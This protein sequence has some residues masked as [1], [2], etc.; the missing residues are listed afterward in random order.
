LFFPHNGLGVDP[1]IEHGIRDAYDAFLTG[2]F[3][4]LNAFFAPDAVYVNPS[5]AVESGTREGTA[6]LSKV[7]L[8]L[9]EMFQFTE[10]RV[11]EI[12]EGPEG[13]F[14]MLRLRGHGRVSGAPTLLTQAHVLK[15]R[16]GRAVSLA[17]FGTRE[18]G[19]RAA[20]LP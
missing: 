16:D 8:S 3:E 7:W 2:D 13:V 1:A 11:E 5:Y 17:W 14:V 10:A 6:E 18:E 19:L 20:G 15:L 4:R 9:H 12:Q